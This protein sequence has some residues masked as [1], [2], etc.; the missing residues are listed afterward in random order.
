[1]VKLRKFIPKEFPRKPRSLD[2]LHHWK[3]TEFHQF[4]AYTGIIA[5][6]NNVHEDI[7]YEFLTLHCAYRLLSNP[8]HVHTNIKQAN[9]LLKLFVENFSTVFGTNSVSFNVH[10]LLHLASCAETY[11]PLNSFSAYDFENKLQLLKKH[12]RK[13]SSILKQIVQKEKHTTYFKTKNEEIKYRKDLIVGAFVNDCFIS[14]EEPNNICS[15][16]SFFIIKIES[17]IKEEEIYVEGRRLLDLD[18]FYQEP[19]N[20]CELGIYKTN[21]ALGEKEK[22]SIR[23]VQFKFVCLPMNSYFIIIPILHSC[24]PEKCQANHPTLPKDN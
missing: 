5:L 11:G 16:E 6:Y 8:R 21:L 14:W 1:M 20:S 7:F 17:I 22:F 4:L 18:S 24:L 9:D 12:V 15:V 23:D 3:A 2:D 13:P 10:N 19:I